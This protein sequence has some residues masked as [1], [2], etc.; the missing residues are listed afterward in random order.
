MHRQ[1]VVAVLFGGRSVEHEI[2]IISALQLIGALDTTRYTPVPV[3]VAQDGAWYTGD[4]LFDRAFYQDLPGSLKQVDR[5]TLL[6]LPGV[7]GLSRLD[8]R[9]RWLGRAKADT[10]AIDVFFPVFHG[11]YGEDGSMQ[12]LFELADVVYTGSGV[13]GSAMGMN[14]Y[15][16]KCFARSQDVP[17]LPG[18][19][20]GKHELARGLAATR[21]RVAA[22]MQ[23]P[24]F[25]KPCNLGSS[26]GIGRADDD[27]GLDAALLRVFEVDSQALVEPCVP[28]PFE[29][30]VAVLGGDGARASVLE[31]PLVEDGGILGYEEKYLRKGGSKG[32]SIAGGTAG[33]ARVIDPV[34]LPAS[35]KLKAQEYAIRMFERLQCSGIARVD[36]ICTSSD[37]EMYFNEI[38]TL[39]GSLAYYLWAESQPPLLFT[40]LINIVIERAELAKEQSR[41]L[42]R[43]FGFRSLAV[44]P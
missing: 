2:S 20:V 23:Y 7:G 10:I 29:V 34:D 40:D 32:A 13:L 35:F 37:G 12:G 17:V 19:L 14:K 1:K 43:S 21:R 31:I 3:Y 41:E 26:I 18:E 16:A 44:H 6:P 28:R 27:R 9:S 25:V 36:F 4:A 11:T 22:A 8:R 24:L 5:V 42:R 30:N 38:N 39:P 33:T 15:V